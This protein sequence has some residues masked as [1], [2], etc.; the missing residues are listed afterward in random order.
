MITLTDSSLATM[1]FIMAWQSDDASH[2]EHY[3]AADVNMWRDIF[4][5]ALR[6]KLLGSRPGDTVSHSLIATE[7]FRGNT[8]NIVALPLRHWQPPFG[9]K[10]IVPPLAGRYY[11]QGF[12][13]GASGIYPQTLS[14]MRVVSVN[15]DTFTVDLNHPLSGRKL[16][17]AIKIEAISQTRKER[18]GRCSDRLMDMLEN[19][20]GMQARLAGNP[21]MFDRVKAFQRA[22]PE[23]DRMFYTAPRMVSHMDDQAREHLTSLIGCFLKPGNRVLDLMAS[24]D[25]HLPPHHGL[26][27]TGLGMNGEEMAANPDLALSIVHDLNDD[28]LLPFPDRSFDVVLCNLSIE[29]LTKPEIVVRET[30]RVLQPAGTL[31]VS[32]SNRWFPPKVTR[33]WTELHE[34]ERMGFVLQLCWPHYTNLRTFSFRNWPRPSSD[35][36]FPEMTAGDPLYVVAGEAMSPMK[37]IREP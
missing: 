28:P 16:G 12:V 15:S 26:E 2:E 35:K 7:I 24:V 17:V 31:L 23:D 10:S 21:I 5:D 3:L 14:P 19:G 34:F 13:R 9:N 18:G 32:F 20:P 6:R 37:S 25:S 4:P 22:D 11:P 27:V 1:H 33:I 30:A 29:Y 8:K 36:H